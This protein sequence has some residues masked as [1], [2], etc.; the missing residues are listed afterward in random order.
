[1]IA[2]ISPNS[3]IDKTFWPA[4]MYFWLF[5]IDHGWYEIPGTMQPNFFFNGEVFTWP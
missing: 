3:D 4:S 2:F 5:Y 1:M